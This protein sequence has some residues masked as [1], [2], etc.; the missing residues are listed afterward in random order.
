MI[1]VTHDQE[2]AMAVADRIAVM[3]RGRI[4]QVGTPEEVYFKPRTPFVAKFVSDANLLPGRLIESGDGWGVAEV[5][6][7][8]FL[9]VR[10]RGLGRG[11]RVVVVV[12]PEELRLR[13][14]GV[15]G[16]VRDAA[17]LGAFTRLWVEVNGVTLKVDVPSA[18]SPR[19]GEEVELRLPE[20]VLALEYPITGLG[21]LVE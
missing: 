5:E 2:E 4:E 3:R 19:V 11:S 21:D 20:G 16:V 8:G 6:G 10:H 12:R 9:K 13:A 7:L 18:E 17:Y 14:G 15:K 1:H